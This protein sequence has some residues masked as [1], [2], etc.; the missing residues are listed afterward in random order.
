MTLFR[1][2]LDVL[3]PRWRE[4]DVSDVEELRLRAGQSPVV[5][6]N[7]GQRQLPGLVRQEELDGILERATQH[8]SY[9]SIQTLRQGFVTLPGGHR[10]GVCGSAVVKNGEMT[11]FRQISSL[12][13][14]FARDVRREGGELLPFLTESSLIIGAP[15]AGKTTLLRSCIRALSASGRRVCVCDDRSEISAMTQ[16]SA[17]FDLGPQTDVLTGLEKSEAMM[18]LLRV[19]DPQWIAADEITQKRDILAMEQISYCGVKLLATAHAASREELFSRPLY[20]E[21]MALGVFRRLFVLR[22]DRQFSVQEAAL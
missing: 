17:Q 16:G 6:E 14:R 2:I 7:G 1:E 21:L 13:I 20:R 9:S 10:I 18:M 12:C 15:G 3:P 11:G 22:P 5:V 4:L 8:S 19:M